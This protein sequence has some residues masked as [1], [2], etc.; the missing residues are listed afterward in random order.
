MHTHTHTHTVTH[1]HTHLHART[2][3]HTDTHTCQCACVRTHAWHT[4][5]PF[6]WRPWMPT[7]VKVDITNTWF[8]YVFGAILDWLWQRN[9]AKLNW[10]EN[11]SQ[12]KTA[13]S[14]QALYGRDWLGDYHHFR[15]PLECLA[16]YE[17]IS[18]LLFCGECHGSAHN[19]ETA[20]RQEFRSSARPPVTGKNVSCILIAL[21]P[22]LKCVVLTDP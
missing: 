15:L 1:A 12:P 6:Q 13:I 7:E 11:C 19:G 9:A 3:S 14:C 4:H 21:V 20:G 18:L 17:V 8:G 2:L 5:T 16:A 10:H 22:R